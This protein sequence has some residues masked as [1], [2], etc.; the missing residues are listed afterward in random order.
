MASVKERCG[1]K[2]RFASETNVDVYF[3]CSLKMDKKIAQEEESLADTR[4]SK[5]DGATATSLRYGGGWAL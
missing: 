1:M 5:K 4:G 2:L 3:A